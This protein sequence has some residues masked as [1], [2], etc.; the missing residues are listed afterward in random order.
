MFSIRIHLCQIFFK[1]LQPNSRSQI[2]TPYMQMGFK[3]FLHLKKYLKRDCYFLTSIST[4]ATLS[5][6]KICLDIFR[7]ISVYMCQAL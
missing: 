3:L 4:K 1:I 2:F 5:Q 6:V 7:Y